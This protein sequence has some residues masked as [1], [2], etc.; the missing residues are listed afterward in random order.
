MAAS[1]TLTRNSA[2]NKMPALAARWM[3]VL[4]ADMTI[5]PHLIIRIEVRRDFSVQCRTCLTK[6]WAGVQEAKDV[7]EVM[8]VT[9]N[10]SNLNRCEHHETQRVGVLNATAGKMRPFGKLNIYMAHWPVP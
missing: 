2:P 7:N 1:R 6:N 5:S 8:E 4:R 3:N 10:A 9:E